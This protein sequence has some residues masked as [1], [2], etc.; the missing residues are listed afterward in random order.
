MN[1]R[2]L[3]CF[4]SSDPS[5]VDSTYSRTKKRQRAKPNAESIHESTL[6]KL[7]QAQKDV[8]KGRKKEIE[9]KILKCLECD[10]MLIDDAS[11]AYSNCSCAVCQRCLVLHTC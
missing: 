2:S 9:L 3:D 10:E 11:E 6:K 5:D 8:A 1:K 7:F 4:S